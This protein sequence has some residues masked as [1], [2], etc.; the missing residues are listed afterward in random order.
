[1]KHPTLSDQ[2][3]ITLQV[4]SGDDFSNGGDIYSIHK[5]GWAFDASMTINSSGEAVVMYCG[6]S[7]T[8]ACSQADVSWIKSKLK[9]L[10]IKLAYYAGQSGV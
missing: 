2:E 10:G 5:D 9:D 1:M 3:G 7:Q 4:P 8:G 6:S